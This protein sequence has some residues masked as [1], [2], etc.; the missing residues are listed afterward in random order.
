MPQIR[1]SAVSYLNTK[2][3]IY[4]L[5]RSDL[6]ES[7]DLSLDIPSVCAQKLLAGTVDLALT[8]VAIIPE[9]SQAH[10]VSNY[11]IGTV[12][13]VKTVCIYAE[14]PL[15]EITRIYLDFHSR[16]SVALTK[17]LCQHHW[18]ITAELIPATPGFENQIN[19]DHAALI[20]GDRTIALQDRYPF[21]Y[22]LGEAWLAWTGL[23]FVFAAWIAVKPIDTVLMTQFNQALQLG[24]DHI[25][26]LVKILP[27]MANFDI[28][29]YFRE[30]IS[31]NL[32]DAK[33]QGLQRF[34][35]EIA[36]EEGYRL[37]RTP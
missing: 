17:L 1:I 10:I 2:P 23:P 19:G 24:I 9:L 31:Y 28:E 21:V 15:A 12:G 22:D 36:G 14:K 8:P 26:E 16:S 5:F 27:T 37:H 34:L 33:W 6:A 25:P 18:K 3:F 13:R 30:N 11:C 32:D 20:I 29:A 4:G 7:I 35:H